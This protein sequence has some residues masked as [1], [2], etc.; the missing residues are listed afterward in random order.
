MEGLIKPGD[1]YDIYMTND[2]QY[3]DATILSM[4]DK[5]MEIVRP[6]YHS[7]DEVNIQ[8]SAIIPISLIRLISPSDRHPVWFLETMKRNDGKIYRR[9]MHCIDMAQVDI[10]LSADAGQKLFL[11]FDDAYAALKEIKENDKDED[12]SLFEDV[13]YF[14]QSERGDLKSVD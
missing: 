13:E 1:K 5:W 4:D 3:T 6:Y 10:D 8:Q 7:K 11:S 12:Q 14:V 2:H 9:V